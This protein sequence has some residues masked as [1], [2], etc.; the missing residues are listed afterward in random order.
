MVTVQF[1]AA[2]VPDSEPDF[3]LDM[4]SGVRILSA[5]PLPASEECWRLG[6]YAEC[7]SD[8]VNRKHRF[9][10]YRT[11]V[12]M[13]LPVNARYVG[14]VSFSHGAMALHIYFLGEV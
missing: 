5:C 14:T 13:D 9:R 2:N 8:S 6:L 1:F 3:Y 11:S 12:P 10:A 4:P 7:R